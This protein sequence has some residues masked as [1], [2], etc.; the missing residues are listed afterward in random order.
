MNSK[1]EIDNITE[2]ELVKKCIDFNRQYQEM[3]YRKFSDKMFNVCLNYTDNY[4]EA[5]DVL[6]EGFIKIFRKLHQF[7]FEG[8]L[9]GWI[10]KVIVNTALE[11]Y[12]KKS[13]E[14]EKL[15]ILT[16]SQEDYSD[17]FLST[18]GVQEIIELVNKLPSKAQI[19]LK[20][21]AIEGYSHKE[22]ASNLNITEG[23]SKSQL[24]RARKLLQEAFVKLNG[25]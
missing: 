15:N 23:T 1:E 8:S 14:H 9:E 19:V 22:I 5:S 7:N 13:R 16:D 20:L 25:E 18:F 24:N 6:Q 17:D 4:D 12:R 3:L 2:V 21:Y 11:N 10:R